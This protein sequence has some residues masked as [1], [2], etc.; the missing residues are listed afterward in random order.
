[1]AKK[2]KHN[3]LHYTAATVFGIVAIL[4]LLRLIY[5]WQLVI[6]TWSAPM[7]LSVAAL[8]LAGTLAVLLWRSA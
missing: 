8:L 1:M 2:N 4:H 5:G 7:W 6:G 3:A